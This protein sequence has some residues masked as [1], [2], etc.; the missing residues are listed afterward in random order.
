MKTHTRKGFTLIELL[1]VV[2]VIGILALTALAKFQGTKDRA[3]FAAV[4]MDLKGIVRAQEAYYADNQTYS[5]DL[6]TL[7]YSPTPMVTLTITSAG[8][9]K[10]WSAT[11]VHSSIAAA[12]NSCSI[13]VGNDVGPGE[14]DGVVTCP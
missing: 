6:T 11:G 10:G 4:K 1:T 5:T 8:L 13:H 9:T 7:N 2:V 3:Y 14:T 12:A